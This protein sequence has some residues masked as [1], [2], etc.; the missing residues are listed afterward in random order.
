MYI[1][2]IHTYIHICVYISMYI[3]TCV[4]IN[5]FKSIPCLYIH[6]IFSYTRRTRT[7][8]T[9]YIYVCIHICIYVYTY[10]YIYIY[11]YMYICTNLYSCFACIGWPRTHT[12]WEDFI[13][14]CMYTYVGIYACIFSYTP[15]IYIHVQC[16][17]LL[18]FYTPGC[19]RRTRTG[20]TVYLRVSSYIYLCKYIYAYEYNIFIFVY[21]RLSKACTNWEDYIYVSKYMYVHAYNKFKYILV[22]IRYAYLYISGC[23]RRA[24]VGGLYICYVC[25]LH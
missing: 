9:I 15:N 19:E 7:E 18:Y 13:Y 22:Y 25:I 4:Y 11:V 20:R 12:N 23:Q 3:N 24:Q 8:R 16:V 2:D 14:V 5:L 6:I 17:F 21:I 10:M 1:Y